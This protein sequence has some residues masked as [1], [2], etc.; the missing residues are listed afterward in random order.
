ML[1]LILD[2]LQR[3]S[4]NI[5][6]HANDSQPPISFDKPPNTCNIPSVFSPPPPTVDLKHHPYHPCDDCPDGWEFDDDIINDNDTTTYIS[7]DS[8]PSIS[9]DDKTD[10]SSD[11]NNTTYLLPTAFTS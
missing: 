3:P 7:N 2:H 10:T 9:F 11:K 8:Q 5:N 1:D 4:D 6:N